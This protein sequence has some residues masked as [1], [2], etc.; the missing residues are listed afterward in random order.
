MWNSFGAN[1]AKY[2]SLKSHEAL[3]LDAYVHVTSPIRRLVDILTMV[4]LQEKLGLVTYS[5]SKQIFYDKWTSDEA[6]AYINKTMRSIRKVQNDC[7]LL[8]IC[9]DD[10]KTLDKIYDGYIF[11]K[12]IRNDKLYQYMV[13]LPELKTV[14]RFTSRYSK[15]NMSQQKFKLYVFFFELLFFF[16]FLEPP[17]ASFP[18]SGLAPVFSFCARPGGN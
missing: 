2:E 3:D 16:V 12:I 18:G 14:N 17:D 8:K 9:Y 15:E 13:Y 1:Y 7:S 6:I 11:D 10:T 5:E 4:L